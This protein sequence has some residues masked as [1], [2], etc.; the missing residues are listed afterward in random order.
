MITALLGIAQSNCD[1]TTGIAT[2]TG[3]EALASFREFH[4][5]TEWFWV[6]RDLKAH[7]FPDPA[8]SRDTFH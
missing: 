2:Y 5:I 6:G 8:L 1:D 7:P 3:I 4:R